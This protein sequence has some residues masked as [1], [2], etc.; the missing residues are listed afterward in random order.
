MQTTLNY[1]PDDETANVNLAAVALSQ[2][3]ILKAKTLLQHAGNG[4]A[5]EQLRA[6]IDIVEG[7]YDTAKRHLD[8]AERKGI[9]VAKN[10]EAIRL[11]TQ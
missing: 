1:Y 9:N 6:V 10:R 7:N 11:L 3:D 5:A 4:G 8:A 2:R